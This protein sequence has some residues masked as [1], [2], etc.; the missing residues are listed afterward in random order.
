MSR[1]IIRERGSGG[2][3]EEHGSEK[4]KRHTSV[5]WELGLKCMLGFKKQW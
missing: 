4:V 1:K 2:D 3:A 5:R